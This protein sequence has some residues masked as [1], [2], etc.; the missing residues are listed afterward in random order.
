M[1]RSFSPSVRQAGN[2]VVDQ[3]INHCSQSVARSVRQ[4]VNQSINQFLKSVNQTISTS[5]RSVSI[6]EGSPLKSSTK[7]EVIT[8]APIEGNTITE[9]SPA[10]LTIQLH[11][12]LNKRNDLKL[13]EVCIP[14]KSCFHVNIF[15]LQ[16]TLALRT[17]RYYGHP[18]NTYSN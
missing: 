5:C 16:S 4:A 1:G 10:R 8:H 6:G 18:D 9:I 2:I 11:Y 14:C 7:K 17:P 3:S 13:R 12:I 15:P